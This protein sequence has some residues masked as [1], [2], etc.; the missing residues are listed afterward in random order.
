[1][2]RQMIIFIACFSNK[3][4]RGGPAANHLGFTPSCLKFDHRDL[5]WW[6]EDNCTQK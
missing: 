2:Q 5:V 1:M 6:A 3:T 4:R